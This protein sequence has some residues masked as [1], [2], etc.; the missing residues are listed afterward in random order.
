MEERRFERKFRECGIFLFLQGK[1]LHGACK[2]RGFVLQY[3]EGFDYP[4]TEKGRVVYER[5]YPEFPL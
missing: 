3:K 1:I 2:I 4:H 5:Y